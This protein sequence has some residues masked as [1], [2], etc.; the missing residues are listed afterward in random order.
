MI[1]ATLISQ[2]KTLSVADRIELIGCLETLP[3]E[4]PFRRRKGFARRS[5]GGMEQNPEHKALV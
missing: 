5:P 3:S 2:V 1:N 4:V